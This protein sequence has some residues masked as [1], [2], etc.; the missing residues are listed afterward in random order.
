MTK[1]GI[2]SFKQ[3]KSGDHRSFKILVEALQKLFHQFI[4]P[5]WSPDLL[6]KDLCYQ[7][8]ASVHVSARTIL[9]YQTITFPDIL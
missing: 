9:A 8:S 1:D 7:C 5:C 2:A 6:E 4:L 3:E